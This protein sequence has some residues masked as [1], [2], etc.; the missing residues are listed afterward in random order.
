[1][2]RPF[3]A[4]AR[5]KTVPFQTQPEEEAV[6]IGEIKLNGGIDTYTDPADLPNNKFQSVINMKIRGDRLSR[7]Q[8]TVLLTPAKPNSDRVLLYCLFTR[9]SG[10][11]IYLRFTKNKIYRKGTSAWTEII[12]ATPFSLT[13]KDRIN[14]TTLNDRFFFATGK[15]PICEINFTLN[16][17]AYLGNAPAYKYITGFFNRLVGF[18]LYD[19]VTP[20]PTLAGWSGDLNFAQWNPLIDISAGS[21]PILEAGTDFSDPHVGAFGFAA[22]TL[23][24]RERSLW[25]A[26]K[27]P[28]AT[29]PFQF[30]A[31]FPFAGCDTPNS[32]TQKKNGIVWYD[33]RTNEVYDYTIGSS[34]RGIGLPIKNELKSKITDKSQVYGSYDGN[35]DEYILS[36]VSELTN[37]TYHYIYNYPAE[38]WEIRTLN[39]SNGAVVLDNNVVNLKIDD[40]SGKIDSLSGKINDLV[41][42][43]NAPPSIF[44]MTKTGEILVESNSDTDN[45]VTMTAEVVS[46][47]YKTPTKDLSISRF[48]VTYELTRTGSFQIYYSKDGG[49]TYKLYK[50]VVI[51]QAQLGMRKRVQCVKH[52]T[53]PEFSWKITSSAG[54]FDFLDYTISATPMEFTRR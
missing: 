50:N 3:T 36:I 24:L 32:A 41:S 23:I 29:N 45:G 43:G 48:T 42:S 2:S 30:Q 6:L 8:G 5:G 18:N 13:D 52:I 11:A 12:S 4:P 7:A 49:E 27:V 10:E 28:V 26:I 47:I 39:G 34:P 40:L 1:M 31:T 51:A 37:T 9:F 22:V 21:A 16:T 53:T 33:Y 14:F 44:F 46:K 19:A 54:D 17:Y 35:N 20:N 25:T 15:N 38:A